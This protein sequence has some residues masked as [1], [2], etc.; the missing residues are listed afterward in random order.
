[1]RASNKSFSLVIVLSILLLSSCKIASWDN[2]PGKAQ[3]S[4]PKSIQGKYISHHAFSPQEDSITMK[5]D[6][7]KDRVVFYKRG[8]NES[9]SI[10][11][12]DTIEFSRYKDWYFFNVKEEKG[13]SVVWSV[14]PVQIT[15]KQEF[16]VYYI[17]ANEL[18]REALE[19]EFKI[20]G[21]KLY[22]MDQDRYASF[23]DHWK[24]RLRPQV[25]VQ[26]NEQDTLSK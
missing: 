25:F 3:K 17:F 14:L 7:F 24:D 21:S 2:Y 13:D 12:G 10:H 1:M 19:M 11:L 18:A 4:V 16:R 8:T 15:G 9:N 5:L 20:E 6:V 23:C 26:R 22:H